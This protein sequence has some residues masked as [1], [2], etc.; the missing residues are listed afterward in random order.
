MGRQDPLRKITVD[1]HA[2]LYRAR[3]SKT[4]M[5]RLTFFLKE[6]SQRF[7][8]ELLFPFSKEQDVDLGYISKD[9]VIYINDQ[10]FNLNRPAVVAA[11]IRKSISAGWNPAKGVPPDVIEPIKWL[12]EAAATEPNLAG[13]ASK[14]SAD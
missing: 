6:G 5:Q 8:L 13:M 14:W 2:Y 4:E 7:R 11:L 9:G 1:G 3:Q 10:A 12:K